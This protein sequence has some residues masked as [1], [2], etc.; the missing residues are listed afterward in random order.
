ML[1][2]EPDASA[3]APPHYG[4]AGSVTA[5][6]ALNA[7]AARMAAAPPLRLADHRVN[8]AAAALGAH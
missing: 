6:A 1:R 3:A 4:V 8:L 5:R 2:P 7:K